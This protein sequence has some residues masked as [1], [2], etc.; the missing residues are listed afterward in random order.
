MN[1]GA[2]RRKQFLDTRRRLPETGS[3]NE[4]KCSDVTST[5]QW[6]QLMV[7]K[8][9]AL[10]EPEVFQEF[11]LDGHEGRQDSVSHMEKCRPSPVNKRKYLS[12]VKLDQ[13]T[14]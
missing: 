1:W 5:T 4:A 6:R 8:G 9:V 13:H 3:M 11:G 2:S 7:Q 14:L 12:F 10:S